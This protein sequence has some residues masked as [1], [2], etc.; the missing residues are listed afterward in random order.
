MVAVYTTTA[1]HRPVAALQVPQRPTSLGQKHFGMAAAGPFVL[2]DDLIGRSS[3]NGHRA[4]RHQSEDVRPLGPLANDQVSQHLLLAF[5]HRGGQLVNKG[6][7]GPNDHAVQYICP[8]SG[9]CS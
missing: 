2:D 6:T 3:A 7:I 9:Y 5:C 1:D 4:S 8:G